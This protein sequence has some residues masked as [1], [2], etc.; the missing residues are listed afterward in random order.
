MGSLVIVGG[1]GAHPGDSR[2][3]QPPVTWATRGFHFRRCLSLWSGAMTDRVSSRMDRVSGGRT[4]CHF[5]ALTVDARA[6][7]H[8]SYFG[9]YARASLYLAAQLLS[10]VWLEFGSRSFDQQRGDKCVDWLFD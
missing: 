9:A 2:L 5:Y 10:G 6:R 8:A 7:H 1:D 4:L 3:L